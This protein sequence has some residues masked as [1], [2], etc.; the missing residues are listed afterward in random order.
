MATKTKN[1]EPKKMTWSDRLGDKTAKVVLQGKYSDKYHLYEV[2]NEHGRP[3]KPAR[4]LC[5]DVR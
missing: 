3:H 2:F 4:M 1:I 5:L